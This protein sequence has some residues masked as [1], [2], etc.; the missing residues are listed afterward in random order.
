MRNTCVNSKTFTLSH[1]VYCLVCVFSPVSMTTGMACF[2]LLGNT[3]ALEDLTAISLC[4]SEEEQRRCELTL[5]GQP[6]LFA[7]GE[8]LHCGMDLRPSLSS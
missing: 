7:K 8:R 5:C 6:S 3:I 4:I 1:A 2:E